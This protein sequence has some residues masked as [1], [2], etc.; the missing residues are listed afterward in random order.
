M[1]SLNTCIKH[2]T[3]NLRL[4]TLLYD[5]ATLDKAQSTLRYLNELKKLKVVT[6]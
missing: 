2:L 1:A 6:K 4:F 3:I 5:K